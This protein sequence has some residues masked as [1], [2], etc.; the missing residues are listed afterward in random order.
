MALIPLTGLSRRA[1]LRG[2]AAALAGHAL[3]RPAW[4]LVEPTSPLVKRVVRSPENSYFTYPHSNG[5]LPNG[6]CV[7]GVPTSGPNNPGLDYVSFDFRNGESSLI[8]HVRDAR[9]YFAIDQKGML[10]ATRKHGTYLIDAM[11]KNDKPREVFSDPGWTFHS[12]C[13][14]AV[15]GRKIL[16]SRND[17]GRNAHRVDLIDTASGQAE[18]LVERDWLM[19]HAHFSPFDPSWI[20]FA[21]AEPKKYMRL[22]VWNRQQAPEGR[23]LFNQTKSD[24]KVFDIGHERAM[25]SKRGLLVIAYGSNSSARPCGLY[26]VGFDG[27]ARLVSESNRDFHCNIS[28]DGRWAVVSLQGTYDAL[29]QRISSN[30]P[31]ESPGYGFSDVMVVN[32]ATGARQFLYRGTNSAKGQP[33]EVQPTISPDGKWV[34]LKDGREQRVLGIEIDQ[35][36]LSAFLA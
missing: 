5:F 10:A 32:M 19:D 3:A 7:L 2:A 15:D 13:D 26:E 16:V 20:V 36:K 28:R 18:T 31:N 22:W 30:W 35:S 11:Q 21:S 17:E 4:A 23:K 6:A 9:M 33:Y 1:L 12:D 34:L 24:G 27:T 8:T 25:F 14:I 29:M